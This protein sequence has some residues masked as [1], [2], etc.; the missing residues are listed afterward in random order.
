MIAELILSPHLFDS[1]NPNSDVLRTLA[2]VLFPLTSVSP[3]V[4]CEP[5]T[6]DW[7]TAVTRRIFSIRDTNRRKEAMDLFMR[8][9]RE[10]LVR[11]PWQE[12]ALGDCESVWVKVAR[13]LHEDAPLDAVVTDESYDDELALRINKINDPDFWEN[14]RNPRLVS[15]NLKAQNAALRT[16]C[17]HS[18][19]LLV[20]MPYLK[21]SVD[22]EIVTV[23][24]IIQLASSL[25]ADSAGGSVTVQLDNRHAHSDKFFRNVA[26]ELQNVRQQSVRI[27]VELRDEKI[28][29]R[30]LLGGEFAPRG[31]GKE[32]FHRARWF[33]Q[34]THV[35]IGGAGAHTEDNSWN[36][37][38][39]RAASHR[40]EAI[41]RIEVV[42]SSEIT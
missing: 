20:R 15:R 29:N 34:M 1:G 2:Q 3:A 27:K 6:H 11:R 21:G 30:E 24:Q 22:D 32:P 16:V 5:G 13:T 4:I 41:Q 37:F 42:D 19:W 26:S 17:L 31:E 39:R 33:M 40:L 18:D 10:L 23:K 28:L 35:A 38:D 25:K 14:Y 7:R 8:I 36:L 9:D 12:N